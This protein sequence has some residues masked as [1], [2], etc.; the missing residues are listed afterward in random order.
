MKIKLLKASVVGGKPYKA[1]AVVDVTDSEA[2]FMVNINKAVAYTAPKP[3]KEPASKSA[4]ENKAVKIDELE[5][6]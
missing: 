5:T 4:P 3:K 6:R 2:R 1:G